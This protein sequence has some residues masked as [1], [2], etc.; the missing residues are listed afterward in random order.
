MDRRQGYFADRAKDGYNNM[1]VLEAYFALHIRCCFFISHH[2]ELPA[3]ICS[4][5]YAER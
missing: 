4:S 1:I 5:E 3:A 2:T